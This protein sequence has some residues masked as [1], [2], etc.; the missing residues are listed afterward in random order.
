MS[1]NLVQDYL[2]ELGLAS[3]DRYI[4]SIFILDKEWKIYRL[5]DDRIFFVYY[6]LTGKIG[7]AWCAEVTCK[8]MSWDIDPYSQM[9]SY[10]NKVKEHWDIDENTFNQFMSIAI[11]ILKPF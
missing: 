11:S 5:S 8:H 10:S 2:E 1:D 9:V 6:E 3:D 7:Y 4:D